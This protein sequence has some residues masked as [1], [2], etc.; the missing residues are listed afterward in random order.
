[1]AGMD[2]DLSRFDIRVLATSEIDDPD[3]ELMFALFDL[4]Y[5]DANHAYLE[6]SFG[7]LRHVAIARCEGAPAG[8]SL[9]EMR[10]LDL[11]RLPQQAVGMA[12]ICCVAPQFRRMGLFRA[13]EQRAIAAA[14]IRPAGR[15][16]SCGRMAHPA[17]MRLM[18]RNPTVVPKPGVEPSEWQR[19]VGVAIAEAYG[20]REFDPRTFVYKGDG[21][22]IGY[23]NIEIDVEPSEW[24]AFEH[25]DRDRGDSLLGV[26]WMPDAPPGW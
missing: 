11:P 10:V 21:K 13:L 19:A 8:F 12:G 9:G 15:M 6:K 7:R 22:P 1:M 3:R 4:T 20:A 2:A 18:A 16:L 23:P 17:S 25:V 14:G 5:R 24:R 26:V